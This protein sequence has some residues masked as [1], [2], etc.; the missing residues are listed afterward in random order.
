[1][2]TSRAL[3]HESAT[4]EK[5]LET[6]ST[7]V[8]ATKAEHSPEGTR[9]MTIST[10]CTYLF[11]LDSNATVSSTVAL[12]ITYLSGQKGVNSPTVF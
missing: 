9:A 12:R 5:N 10:Q 8:A 7:I 1:M 11:F 2:V 6:R 4:L 3:A